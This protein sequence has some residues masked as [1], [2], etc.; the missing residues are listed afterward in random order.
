MT[1]APTTG[2]AAEPAYFAETLELALGGGGTVGDL[3][4]FRASGTGQ[5]TKLIRGT[6]METGAKTATANGT[7]RQL[8][9]VTATQYL[10]ACLHVIAVSGTNPTLDVIVASDDASNFGSSTTRMTFTQKTAIGSQFIT[11]VAGAI[12]DDYWRIVYTIGGT[13]TPTFN[14][15]VTVGIL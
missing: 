11:P 9:A 8:G 2:A 5:G 13:N 6:I 1:F 3:Y 7:A 15:I 4:M 14:F 12:T 10:Y